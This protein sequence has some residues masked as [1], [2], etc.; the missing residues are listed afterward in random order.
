MQ[1]SLE[2]AFLLYYSL[3][4][5]HVQ[6]RREV[7]P[8]FKVRLALHRRQSSVITTLP[9]RWMGK[10]GISSLRK[11]GASVLQAQANVAM[12]IA[13]LSQHGLCL[14]KSCII[15]SLD[16]SSFYPT[17]FSGRDPSPSPFN[18]DTPPQIRRMSIYRMPRGVRDRYSIRMT[19]YTAP[20]L[21]D[22]ISQSECYISK[23]CTRA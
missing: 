13:S 23:Y 5:V 6:P 3:F 17:F 19:T 11:R 15:R 14:W 8:R 18:T 20:G 7:R 4:V 10:D 21:L 22:F 9:V 1:A 2:K 16:V 12:R